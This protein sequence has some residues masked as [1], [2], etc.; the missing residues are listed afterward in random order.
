MQSCCFPNHMLYPNSYPRP[1][2]SYGILAAFVAFY[3]WAIISVFKQVPDEIVVFGTP[4][5]SR[6][7]VEAWEKRRTRLIDSCLNFML[8]RAGIEYD[9]PFHPVKYLDRE[10]LIDL[11]ELLT[12]YTDDGPMLN[13]DVVCF[14]G[15][16]V[17]DLSVEQ[18]RKFYLYL[19]HKYGGTQA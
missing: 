14:V 18:L 5:H 2:A 16:N 6:T 1:F 13:G 12:A 10:T 15:R 11:V 3:G 9:D 8:K 17:R 7:H 4:A 19:Y